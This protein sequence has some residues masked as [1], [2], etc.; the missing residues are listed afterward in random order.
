MSAKAALQTIVDTHKAGKLGAFDENRGCVYTDK[1]GKHCAVGAL[2]TPKLLKRVEVHNLNVDTN[3]G[4]LYTYPEFKK[5]FDNLGL[6]EDQLT[7]LQVAHD[8]T[9][10]GYSECYGPRT[11]DEFIECLELI[12]AGEA[13]FLGDANFS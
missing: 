3:A 13:V 1:L 8:N 7:A 10:D 2:L 11:L 6:D 12:I 5:F 4:A 9:F